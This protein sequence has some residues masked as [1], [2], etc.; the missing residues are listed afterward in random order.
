MKNRCGI[1]KKISP[2]RVLIMGLS[3]GAV[4]FVILS[5]FVPYIQN[6]EITTRSIFIGILVF[7]ISGIIYGIGYDLLMKRFNSNE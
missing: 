5:L 3:W 2:K 4:M 7:S 1:L 6:E